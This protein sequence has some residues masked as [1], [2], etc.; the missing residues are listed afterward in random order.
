VGGNISISSG[1][2]GTNPGVVILSCNSNSITL[3]NTGLAIGAPTSGQS[4]TITGLLAG[5]AAIQVN[6]SAT[7]GSQI[8]TFTATNKPGTGTTAP[9][10][11]MPII[12]DG[13]TYYIPCWT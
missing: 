7:T 1:N 3:S 5:A 11:W 2:G 10:V 8:A 13:T 6:T 4:V 12:L 9:S